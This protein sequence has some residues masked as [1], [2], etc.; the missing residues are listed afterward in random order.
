[1]KRWQALGMVISLPLMLLGVVWQAGRQ[2]ALVAETR[3]LERQQEAWVEANAKLVGG[4]AVL[5]SRQRASELATGLGL[6]RAAASRRIFVDISA[7]PSALRGAE[8]ERAPAADSAG[9]AAVTAPAG[10][11]AAASSS[12]AGGQGNG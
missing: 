1:M 9:S 12:S 2:A 11:A 5:G 3:E 4:I 7:S 10:A 6:E 8:G